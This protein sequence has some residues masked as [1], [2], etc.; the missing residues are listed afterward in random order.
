M[1]AIAMTDYDSG[2]ALHELP[3]PEPTPDELLVGVHASSVNRLDVLA[4]E[5]EL[6]ETMKYEFPVIPGRDFAGT[7]SRIGSSTT[8]F[9]VGDEVFG[10]LTNSVVH[11]GAWADY[12][13]V[14]DDGFIARKPSGVAFSEAAALP[15][16]GVAALLLVEAVDPKAGDTVLVVGAEGGVGGF[17]VQLLARRGATVIATAKRDDAQRLHELGA[18]QTID[19]TH[20]D[21]AVA[22]REGLAALI[23][24]VNQ[25][26]GFA[27]LAELVR[28]GGRAASTLG[29]ADVDGLAK[30]NIE[31]TNIKA[32]ADA[33]AITRL[34][35]VV[36]DGELR[37]TIDSV[38]SLAQ[39]PAAIEQFKTGKRGKIVISVADR[40]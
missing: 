24:L 40:G 22:V 35:E 32:G 25:A 17:A 39:A 21:V 30:R 23:D 13:T 15:L 3:I 8:N 12:V 7:V 29:A 10:F 11:E 37:P 31:A 26:D 4:I 20:E 19:Y 33:S 14:P 36:A 28:E 2:V 5:G 6:P 16:A 1:R 18:A 27:P 34:A 9:A 38:V